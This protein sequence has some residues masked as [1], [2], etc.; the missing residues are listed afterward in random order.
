VISLLYLGIP[1]DAMILR[2][3]EVEALMRALSRRASVFQA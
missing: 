1:R 2:A 3:S